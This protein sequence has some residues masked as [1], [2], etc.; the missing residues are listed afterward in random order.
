MTFDQFAMVDTPSSTDDSQE[1]FSNSSNICGMSR[2]V[3]VYQVQN[4]GAIMSKK[5]TLAAMLAVAPSVVHGYENS[6]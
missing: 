4:D 1:K 3:G 6:G 5:E 2:R